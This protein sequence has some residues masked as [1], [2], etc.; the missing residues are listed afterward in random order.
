M[1]PHWLTSLSRESLQCLA[2]SLSIDGYMHF[3]NREIID[4]ILSV[5]KL[6][7][8]PGHSNLYF[9]VFIGENDI[10][11]FE[12]ENNISHNKYDF[13]IPSLTINDYDNVSYGKNIMIVKRKNNLFVI[14]NYITKI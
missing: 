10:I 12:L 3:S 4:Y 6:W 11:L 13:T 9:K 2:N 1:T 5:Y 14:N 7:E 8:I